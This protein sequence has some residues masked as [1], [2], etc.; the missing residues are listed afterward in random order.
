MRKIRLG[1]YNSDPDSIAVRWIGPPRDDT[2]ANRAEMRE[3]ILA[4]NAEVA[5]RRDITN[6]LGIYR[7]RRR[8]RS[9]S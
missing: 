7:W 5:K 1:L 6:C 4:F 3:S 9:A 8:K 2:P